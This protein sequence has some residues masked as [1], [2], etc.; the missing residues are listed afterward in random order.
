[1]DKGTAASEGDESW[2]IKDKTVT[3][4]GR[5]VEEA[6]KSL[7]KAKQRYEAEA[8]KVVKLWDRFGGPPSPTAATT[9][10]DAIT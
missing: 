5:Q 10:P 1:M 9:Q 4:A 3:D 7:D 6:Q 2:G 8:A